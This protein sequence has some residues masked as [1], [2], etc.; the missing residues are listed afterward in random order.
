MLAVLLYDRDIGSSSEI[1]SYV[2][3]TISKLKYAVSTDINLQ[4]LDE[5]SIQVK[6]VQ[7]FNFVLLYGRDR[8]RRNP[9]KR[10]KRRQTQFEVIKH[11]CIQIFPKTFSL[12]H[13]KTVNFHHM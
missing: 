1:F 11:L 12:G 8:L 3:I 6:L 4:G 9:R 2:Q 7:P 10:G 5:K 13:G